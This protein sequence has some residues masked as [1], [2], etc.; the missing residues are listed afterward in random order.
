MDASSPLDP[1]LA[2]GVEKDA[3]AKQIK[4]A[5]R[6]LVLTCHPDK[7]QDE[8]LKDAKNEEFHRIHEAYELLKDEDKRR[9]YDSAEAFREKLRKEAYKRQ[10]GESRSENYNVRVAEPPWA[11][12]YG[13]PPPPPPMSRSSF[14]RSR[15]PSVYDDEDIYYEASR[16]ASR[17]YEWYEAASS[18]TSKRFSPRTERTKSKSGSAGDRSR[19]D[20]RKSRDQETR[21]DREDKFARYNEDGHHFDDRAMYEEGY[22]RRNEEET[23]RRER[24]IAEQARKYKEQREQPRV[25]RLSTSDSE[26]DDK[27]SKERYVSHEEHKTRS[28]TSQAREHIERVST[29]RNGS[30]SSD[31]PTSGHRPAL[32]RAGSSASS[33]LYEVRKSSESRP[34]VVR[35]SSAR[36]RDHPSSANAHQSYH[37]SSAS[38]QKD[39]DR[40]RDRKNTMPEIVEYPAEDKLSRRA[41][42]SASLAP[43][44]LQ[45][46]RS[47]TFA[48]DSGRRS[49]EQSVPVVS[50]R[51]ADSMPVKYSSSSSV[52]QAP[53]LGA[54]SSSRRKDSH[55]AQSSKLRSAEHAYDSGY[56]SP[57][58]DKAAANGTSQNPN[59]TS[60]TKYYYGSN[61]GSH[62]KPPGMTVTPADEPTRHRTVPPEP[63]PAAPTPKLSRGATF[64]AA[65]T[66]ARMTHSRSRSR[67]RSRDRERDRERERGYDQDRDRDRDSDRNRDRD[68]DR[69]RAERRQRRTEARRAVRPSPQPQQPSH[70]FGEISPTSPPPQPTSYSS[71]YVPPTLSGSKSAPAYKPD[72]IKYQ[73]RFGLEDVR[74]AT[75]RDSKDRY[76]MGRDVIERFERM[77]H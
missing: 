40:E 76:A 9:E 75:G 69:D 61:S 39:R 31:L 2:L 33:R 48:A 13:F 66:S 28:W 49:S 14:D 23:R 45:F 16:T 36:T 51:R 17:K 56:S 57:N 5:F 43:E 29:S 47:H 41:Y 25:R 19:A 63:A 37:T 58:S 55:P 8:S 10:S 32:G 4:K 35:R 6:D 77:G 46:R 11:S 62:S 67:S 26:E 18:P 24:Y 22:R 73:K 38:R 74:Y 64:T 59:G 68:H 12:S 52:P 30:Y 3:D 71:S 1:Y 7:V 34:A 44:E 65:N 21:R 50:V 42:S 15:R 72:E 53:Q 54:P 70:L 20:R 60:T 27:A